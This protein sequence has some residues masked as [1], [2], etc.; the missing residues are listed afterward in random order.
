MKISLA[1]KVLRDRTPEEVVELA[2]Q[3]GYGG[4]EW[5]CLPQHL[6]ADMPAE[7]LAALGRRTRDAGLETVCLST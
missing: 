2:A 4:V 5:F 6:P 7:R 3:L 1:S